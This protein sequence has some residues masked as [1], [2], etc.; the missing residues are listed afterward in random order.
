VKDPVKS[1]RGASL[2]NAASAQEY[3]FGPFRL[4]VAK[5]RVWRGDRLVPLTRKASD[6]LLALLQQ[7]GQVVD[8]ENLLQTVWP[9]TFITE[10]T[11]T[12]NIATIRRAL[13][14]STERP[15]YIATIPRRGYQF[16]G[17]VRSGSADGASPTTTSVG[18]EV[19]STRDARQLAAPAHQRR[20]LIGGA[21]L[22]MIV[23]VGLGIAYY[24]RSRPSDTPLG[25][26]VI[27][28]PPGTRL[29]SGGGLSPDGKSIAFVTIDELG[30]TALWVRA[31]L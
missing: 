17:V 9:N 20:L 4:D 6:T 26:W 29:T 1:A 15:E 21:L 11:L 18:L 27:N 30:E 16:I 28:P 2:I 25:H 23:I 8:K 22:A 24:M 31:I 5:R 3:W 14:D 7:A 19:D 10:E 12:Q 13:G